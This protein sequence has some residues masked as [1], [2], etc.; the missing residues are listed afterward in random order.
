MNFY[1]EA[2]QFKQE[3][4]PWGWANKGTGSGIAL[5]FSGV[6]VK[7]LGRALGNPRG[8]GAIS[9]RLVK[10]GASLTTGYTLGGFIDAPG[11]RVT[12]GTSIGVVQGA[13]TSFSQP[14]AA[15]INNQFQ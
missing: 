6:G 1:Q 5:I 4:N 12:N 3:L 9:T 10:A 11:D 14:L 15:N 8:V 7:A 2:Q 13:R